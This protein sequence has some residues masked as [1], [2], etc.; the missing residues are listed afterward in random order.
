MSLD[1]VFF[2]YW[3]KESLTFNLHDTGDS[4]QSVWSFH[5]T[6]VH[7]SVLYLDVIYPQNVAVNLSTNHDFLIKTATTKEYNLKSAGVERV[8]NSHN[9]VNT[10]KLKITF[11]NNPNN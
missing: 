7:P 10:M 5:L 1:I 2:Q 4:V 11:F 8:Q 3:Y 9:S 6:H